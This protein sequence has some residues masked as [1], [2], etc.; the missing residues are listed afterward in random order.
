MA[1]ALRGMMPRQLIYHYMTSKLKYLYHK[2]LAQEFK[3]ARATDFEN[4]KLSLEE[5]MWIFRNS[6]CILDVP[7]EGRIDDKNY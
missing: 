2:I 6:K 5:M 1:D 3:K 4:E 7:Q